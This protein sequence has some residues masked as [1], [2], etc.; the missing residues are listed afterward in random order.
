MLRSLALFLAGLFALTGCRS[1]T[2]LQNGS[3]EWATDDDDATEEP[4]FEEFD[5]ARLLVHSPSS[6]TIMLVDEGQFL[7]AEVVDIN[8]DPMDF[9]GIV[10]E[11]SL[12]SEPIFEGKQGDVEL[13][14]G[15]HELTVTA[16]LPNGDRLQT[17]LGGIRVQGRQTG[18]YA[19]NMNIDVNLE[20]Q[21]TPVT[22]SCVGGLDFVVDMSG[23]VLG[24]GGQCSINLVVLP[25][26]DVVY[27]VSADVQEDTA[28]GD[29]GID[30]GFFA[31]PIGF[32]GDFPEDG[33]LHADFEGGLLTV[34][35]AGAIDAH[36][37]S[38]YVDP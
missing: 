9:D 26:F 36:R 1:E 27:D 8:G 30:I 17:I 24:G 12:E 29:V 23:E 28:E 16:E 18:V 11:T 6:G 32:T 2:T 3:P 5:G 10:W 25:G 37:V 35:L 19:G 4:Q 20:F 7:D 33:V 38:L 34:Q 22:A 14:W 21:G 13:H 31:L 15:I